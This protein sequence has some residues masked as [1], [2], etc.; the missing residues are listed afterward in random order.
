MDAQEAYL[1][2][3]ERDQLLDLLEGSQRESL[4]SLNGV[5]DAGWSYQ[6]AP[7]RWSVGNIG[8]HLMLSETILFGGV[9]RAIQAGPNP[10]WQL[11]T[12]GK[13]EFLWRVLLNRYE[14]VEAPEVAMP[15]GDLRR[16]D[17]IDEYV[18]ARALTIGFVKGTAYPLK[19]HTCE[20]FFWGVFSAYHWLLHLVLHNQRHNQQMIEVKAD[21]G[22]PH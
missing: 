17:V 5:S 2:P 3:A 13:T 19:A 16:S 21:P 14:R 4:E 20:H 18:R 8:E 10:Q 12:K 1:T 9:D 11:E 15:K 22:F 7:G 6:P